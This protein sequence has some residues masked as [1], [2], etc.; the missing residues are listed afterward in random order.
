MDLKKIKEMITGW[1][2]GKLKKDQLLIL[3]LTGVLLAVVALPVRDQDPSGDGGTK[4]GSDATQGAKDSA[5]ESAQI[6]DLEGRLSRILSQVEGAGQVSVMITLESSAEKVIEKD[7]SSAEESVNESDSQGGERITRNSSREE[8]TVYT[9]GEG[10]EEVPYVRKELSPGIRGVL[11]VATGGGNSAVK[12]E[13]ADAVEALFGI[14][15]HKIR[16]MKRQVA[17]Q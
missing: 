3:F 2:P 1:S 6:R 14:E 10:Q 11:V 15:A 8:T 16:I 9:A 5:E 12:Q 7:S 13:L 17:R 4:E